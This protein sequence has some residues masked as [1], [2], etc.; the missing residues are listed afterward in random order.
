MEFYYNT[1]RTATLTISPDADQILSVYQV[2]VTLTRMIDN[3]VVVNNQAATRV[4]SGNYSYNFTGNNLYNIGQYKLVWTYV[5]GGITST[6]VE[7]FTVVVGYTTPEEVKADFP[8]LASI[9]DADI[10]RKEKLARGII[11]TFCGQ[12]FN[13]E[14]NATKKVMGNNSNNLYLPKRLFRLDNLAVS[15][16]TDYLTSELELFDDFYIRPNWS[17]TGGFFVD[18]K[19]DITE[20]SRYFKS[21]FY[22]DVIGD[23]G[24]EIVPEDI[25]EATKLLILDYFDDDSL[26]R[27]HGVIRA[28]MGDREM[29]FAPDLF[30]TTG[31]YDVDLLLSNYTIMNMRLI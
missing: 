16:T 10:Y 14:L 12:E 9:S 22:Y 26:L 17:T 13:Y 30:S 27:Q 25:Q 18:V 24:W 4:T 20:P 21:A 5:Q 1:P 23:W 29:W 11:D 6:K 19:R 2:F 8:Q 15:G 28:Q 3:V 31:N 7:Y